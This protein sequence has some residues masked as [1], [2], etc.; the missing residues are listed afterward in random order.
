MRLGN[1]IKNYKKNSGISLDNDVDLLNE[2]KG[3][4][5]VMMFGGIIAFLG[6]FVA[7]LTMS[8][9]LAIALIFLGFAFGRFVG[10]SSDGKP[11]KQIIQGLM[12]ELVLGGLNAFCLVMTLL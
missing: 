8:S 6:T 1:P 12:F 3:V 10:I 2:M 4:G 7:V 9:H 11:N 5:S